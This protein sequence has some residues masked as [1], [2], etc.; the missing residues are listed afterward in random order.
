[1]AAFSIHTPRI[2]LLLTGVLFACQKVVQLPLQNTAPQLVIQGEVTNAGGPYQVT[3]TQSVD[4]YQANV[5]PSVSGASVF[6]KDSTG[7][8]TDSLPETSPGIYSTRLFPRG[9]PGHTYTLRV[10][11][12]GQ[13]YTS[14]S[15]MPYPVLLDSVTYE[16]ATL[17]NQSTI[18]PIPNFQDPAGVANYYQFVLFV[19]GVRVPDIFLFDDRLSDGRYIS[20]PIQTDTTDHIDAGD[21]LRLDL[22]CIDKNVYTYLSEVAGI[23]GA[24]PQSSAPA[25]P[26]SNISGG[27][28]GYFSAQTISGKTT[29]VP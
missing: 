7:D 25:N 19:N 21:T 4:F 1:M 17:F 5:F 29:L 14:V 28:L 10:T 15:T 18:N 22:D 9:V 20:E 6:L 27:C 13:V 11:L 16:A 3:I 12:A 26:Q 23:T 2:F 8:I 24:N